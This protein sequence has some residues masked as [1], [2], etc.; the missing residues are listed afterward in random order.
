[1]EHSPTLKLI[2]TS[3]VAPGASSVSPSSLLDKLSG[4]QESEAQIQT[5]ELGQLEGKLVQSSTEVW[6]KEAV[7][8]GRAILS[9][10]RKEIKRTSRSL[11]GHKEK[12]AEL[13]RILDNRPDELQQVVKAWNGPFAAHPES[14]PSLSKQEP[15][16]DQ[17]SSNV[18]GTLLSLFFF[19]VGF[20]VGLGQWKGQGDAPS[21]SES[22]SDR[23]SSKDEVEPKSTVVQ[24]VDDIVDG[25]DVMGP[26][27][28]SGKPGRSWSSLLWKKQ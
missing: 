24:V 11:H 5:K 3:E 25:S 12:V 28:Q 20:Y 18:G 23:W 7:A 4:P 19:V 13:E 26:D 6:D 16:A 8:V 27:P 9:Y 2:H 17:A 22:E 10:Y 21:S 15:D 14:G 1:M